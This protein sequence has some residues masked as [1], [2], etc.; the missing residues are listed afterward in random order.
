[1]AAAT[2]LERSVT[3]HDAL[4]RALT[5]IIFDESREIGQRVDALKAFDNVKAPRVVDVLVWALQSGE[6]ALQAEAALT[7]VTHHMVTHRAQVEGVAALWP[8]D[9]PWPAAAVR[10]ALKE[11]PPGDG[12]LHQEDS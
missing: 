11:V 9:A 7:L 6:F 10:D 12:A 4:I 5:D 8:A 1:M 3:P 2:A